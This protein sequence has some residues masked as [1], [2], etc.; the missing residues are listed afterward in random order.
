MSDRTETKKTIAFGVVALLLAS[1]A[2]LTAPRKVTPDSFADQGE[3]FFPDFQDPNAA[4]TLEVIEFDEA[5]AA[6]R[7][8]KVTFKDGR[9]TIPSHHDYPADGKDRLAKTAAGAIGI[10]KDDYRSNNVTD[11]EACGVLDPLDETLTSLTGRGKRITIKDQADQVLADLIIGKQVE[12]REDRFFVRAP[13]QKRVYVS[14]LDL[15]ISTKFEDWIESD[16]LQVEKEAIDKVTLMDYSINERTRRIERRDTLILTKEGSN[17]EVNRMAAGQEVDN[18]KVNGLLNALDELA[19][20]GVRPKPAGLSMRLSRVSDDTGL[21]ISQA[22]LL[23][24]Q[25]KGYYFGRDGSL[26]SNEGE[27]K[28]ED[29]D[30]VIYTL[31]FGEIVYGTGEALSAGRDQDDQPGEGPGENRYLFIT[32]T[33][34]EGRFPEPRAPANRE[35]EGKQPEELSDGD[36][37]NQELASAHDSWKAKVEKGQE[38]SN[39]LNARFA[40]WYYVISASGYDKIRLKRGDAIKAEAS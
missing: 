1:G 8:F 4:T 9:W 3:L 17:W 35:F 24:L 33:L 6:A 37:R 39:D 28:V 27:L 14:K 20:V 40:D 10:R 19:V 38:R 34:D 29:S 36:Q 18:L 7:P 11:H 32:T 26:L 2:F 21:T 15:A 22:D 12:G 23:S 30:G 25:S 16:L 31:R 13:G 5:T